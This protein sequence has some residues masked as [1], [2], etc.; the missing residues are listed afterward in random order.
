MRRTVLVKYMY[1]AERTAL[2]KWVALDVGP[3]CRLPLGLVLSCVSNL[4]SGDTLTCDG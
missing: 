3:L 4:A 1:M 2:Q